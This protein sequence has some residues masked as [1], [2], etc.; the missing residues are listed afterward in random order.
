MKAYTVKKTGKKLIVDFKYDRQL[1]N[2]VKQIPNIRWDKKAKKWWLPYNVEGAMNILETLEQLPHKFFIDQSMQEVLQEIDNLQRIEKIK[3]ADNLDQPVET[4]FPAWRHQLQAYHYTKNKD[5]VLLYMG[6]GPQPYTAKVLTSSGYVSMGELKIKD[7]VI[8]VNGK[9]TEIKNIKEQGVQRVYEIT[10]S[11]GSKTRSCE[12]HLWN[13]QTPNMKYRNKANYKTISLKEIKKRGLKN[14]QDWWKWFIPM[15]NPVEF[16][17][18]T[19]TKI[20]PYLLGILL[21]DGALTQMVG[22]SISSKEVKKQINKILKR[23]YENIT[24]KKYSKWD[25][26]LTSKRGETNQLLNDLREINLIGKKTIKK[27]IPRE[28]KLAGIAERISLLQGL[29]DSDGS[30]GNNYIEYSTSSKELS[31]DVQFVVE[32][33]GGTAKISEKETY[34]N[35]SY[36][37]HV[38]MKKG[39]VPYRDYEK[40]KNYTLTKA[41]PTRSIRK[42]EVV[43]HEKT[44]CITVE[45]KD[46]LY[47]TDNMIVTH[48]TGKTKVTIDTIM[49]SDLNNVLIVCPNSVV[50]VWREEF[51]KHTVS[52][53]YI[54][55]DSKKGKVADRVERAKKMYRQAKGRKIK[56]IYICNYEIVFRKAFKQFAKEVEFDMIVCDE[57]HKI[58]SHKSE[59]S[60][61]MHKYGQGVKKKICLTGT[62][63]PNSPL[64]IFGQMRFLNDNIFGRYWTKFKNQYAMMGGYGGYQVLGFQNQNELQDKMYQI[65]YRAGSDVLDLP[66][67][68]HMKRYAELSG[69]TLKAYMQ[70]RDDLIVQVEQGELVA[71]NALSKLLRLQQIAS[72]YMPTEET[73]EIVT[74]GTEKIDVFKETIEDIDKD[75]PL[76]IFCRF[77]YDITKVRQALEDVG[78]SVAELSGKENTLKDWR[79]GDYNSIVVQV[80]AGGVGVDLTRAKYC[81]YYSLGFSLG[82][83]E[84]SLARVHRPGQDRNVTYIH[85]VAKNTVDEKIYGALES[86]KKIVTEVLDNL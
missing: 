72:G 18:I 61:A 49:N 27:F 24:L 69:E 47:L 45:N 38:K 73:G 37:M 59:T 58:K 39:I 63:M 14:K 2:D 36:R 76:V 20:D 42:I 4:K 83:Y 17:K 44:R 21:G 7:K 1:V 68:T 33:L 56:G 78:R 71:S 64:D 51:E 5:N 70:M 31:R 60:K 48:N 35:L 34:R 57:S 43:S 82:D 8:G 10:F 79:N 80:Q 66:D 62:P 12:N 77:R 55:E 23:D 40:F 30:T 41:N 13:V 65:T 84:Q 53:K 32:S 25:Y 26:G 74:L 15:T 11:D 3:E 50:E 67:V 9:E 29:F 22:V 75:E 19:G 54:I 81:I 28:Y 46:G 16:K 52:E 86:K 6:M 85:V